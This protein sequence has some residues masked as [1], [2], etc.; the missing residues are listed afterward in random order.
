MDIR[1][2]ARIFLALFAAIFGVLFALVDKGTDL[3]M[4][5][6]AA[7]AALGLT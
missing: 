5:M 2:D 7:I 6:G 3:R 4:M 1:L